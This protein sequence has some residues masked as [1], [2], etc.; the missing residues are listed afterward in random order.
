MLCAKFV[1]NWP[2]G[3]KED[4]FKISLMYVFSL[5]RYYI[6]LEK[7]AALHLNKEQ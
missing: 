4:D 3:S 1:W 2:N 6:Q 7:V 5:F